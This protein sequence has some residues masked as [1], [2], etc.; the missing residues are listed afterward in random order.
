MASLFSGVRRSARL[1]A[2][3]EREEVLHSTP[4]RRSDD[5]SSDISVTNDDSDSDLDYAD[6]SDVM[7]TRA[8]EPLIADQ[9]ATTRV[10]VESDD[11]DDE[12]TFAPNLRVNDAS[13]RVLNE[14]K[15]GSV[16]PNIENERFTE[17]VA[18]N[19]RSFDRGNAGNVGNS[20]DARNHVDYGDRDNIAGRG[21][22][23]SRVNSRDARKR[24]VKPSKWIKP[25][26]FSGS[27]SIE[28]Y[29]SHFET[30]SDYN[31]WS[32]YDKVAHLKAALTGEPAQILWDTGEHAS[33]TY[34]NLAQKLRA[35][36]GSSEYCERYVSQL[37]CLKRRDG[38]SLQ[39][40]HNEV[41]RLMAL[42]FP[43][44]A[45]SPLYRIIGRDAF[46]AA[47]DRELQIKVRDRDPKDLSKVY[48]VAMRVES[49]L[50]DPNGGNT[51]ESNES[52]RRERVG[53]QRTRVVQQLAESDAD[54]VRDEISQLRRELKQCCQAQNNVSRE[55]GRMRSLLESNLTEVARQ[56]DSFAAVR[57]NSNNDEIAR[58]NYRDAT[59]HNGRQNTDEQG[60]FKSAR[61]ECF[62]CGDRNHLV[63]DCPTR[64]RALTD[65]GVADNRNST[66]VESNVS[67]TGKNVRGISDSAKNAAYLRMCINGVLTDFLLDTGSDVCLLPAKYAS[68]SNVIPTEQQLYAANGTAIA[69]D[70]IVRVE[71]IL[72]GHALEIEGYISNQVTEIILGLNFLRNYN[73]VWRFADGMVEVGG[74][75][76][77]LHTRDVPKTCRRVIL[78]SDVI[79]PP[80][81][82]T[83]VST[84]VKFSGELRGDG[85]WATQP[86][87]LTASVLAAGT[88]L[89]QRAVDV[90]VKVIN[91]ANEQ[92]FLPKGFEVADVEPVKIGSAVADGQCADRVLSENSRDI[93]ENMIMCVDSDVSEAN[94]A[95]LRDI[96]YEFADAFSFQE[97][98]IGHATAVKHSIDTGDA[99]PVRQRLR[100]QPPEHQ[101]AIDNSV[102]SMLKRG[103]IEPA[104]SPW[105]ANLVMVRKKSGDYR[106][107]VDFRGLN[108]ITRGDAYSLP[109][110]DACLDALSGLV[111]PVRGRGAR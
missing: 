88:L 97:E 40:L 63:K 18:G 78:D 7:P 73:V 102:S 15:R 1:A 100:R 35:R 6:A 29:L 108:L 25:D 82:E 67:A 27:V 89:P 23:A 26:K 11:T 14:R 20:R 41:C 46:I 96:L 54:D 5:E 68:L 43:G 60:K 31:G 92:V 74:L 79:L 83:I 56:G 10:T 101:A 87:Q 85:D 45:D 42:G 105:A 12:I 53:V 28:S 61:K 64:K 103:I 57:R 8:T 110:I 75:W 109:R 48:E 44:T 111:L 106:A 51:V 77:G 99:R 55:V 93:I 66:V 76:Y 58:D 70:G 36:Y 33:L 13:S 84:Y 19:A 91:T 38:Q 65:N 4:E 62:A 80:R 39:E 21:R 69:V 34:D 90:P 32:E 94:R 50:R 17:H 59:L 9:P 81:A 30:V 47:F 98:D 72:N 3:N 16:K 22:S 24:A 86:R 71:A 37:M 104:Q 49:Y 52:Q 107:C 95:K 2:R